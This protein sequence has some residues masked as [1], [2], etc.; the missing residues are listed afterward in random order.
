MPPITK[1]YQ[2]GQRVRLIQQIPQ[3]DQVW[4]TRLEGTIVRFEQQKTGAWYAHS[5]DDRLW[6]DRLVLQK[7][8]GEQVVCVL[9]RYSHVSVLAEPKA[10]GGTAA[11]AEAAPEA[12]K[13]EAADEDAAAPSADSENK[14]SA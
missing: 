14:A 10:G 3:R 8:D 13:S 1:P 4:T 9:D 6:L 7:D 2:T 5:K 12:D 11:A